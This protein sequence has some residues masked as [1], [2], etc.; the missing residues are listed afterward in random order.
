MTLD[1]YDTLNDQ[2]NN[3]E[4]VTKLKDILGE[5]SAKY[6][7]VTGKIALNAAGDRVSENYDFWIVSKDNSTQHFEWHNEDLK[8]NT[9][10]SSVH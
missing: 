7:G 3:V 4:N 8:S 6:E 10:T 1:K 5:I 9:E 2:K